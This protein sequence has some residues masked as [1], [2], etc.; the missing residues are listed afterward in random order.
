MENIQVEIE[1][2]DIEAYQQKKCTWSI[3]GKNKDKDPHRHTKPYLTKIFNFNNFLEFQDQ[4][5]TTI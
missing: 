2:L 5:F 1:A 3:D 4:I